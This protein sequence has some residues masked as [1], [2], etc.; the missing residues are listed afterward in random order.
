MC[1]AIMAHVALGARLAIAVATFTVAFF[2]VCMTRGT[3][4]VIHNN[5]GKMSDGISSL[6]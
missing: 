5:W 2:H 4:A 1:C 3:F 6:L